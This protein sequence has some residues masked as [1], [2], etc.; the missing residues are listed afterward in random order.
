MHRA[1]LELLYPP[2]CLACAKVLPVRAF[3]CETCDLAVERLPPARCRT[4]AEPGDF[5]RTT[6]PRC[7]ASP[8]PFA[9]A[10]APFAHDGPVARAIHRFKYEDHPELAPSLAELLA[11]ESHHFLSQAPSLVL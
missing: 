9:R 2:A 7:L 3:F 4:C 11:S 1:M 6:C 5:P 8:P 10:S